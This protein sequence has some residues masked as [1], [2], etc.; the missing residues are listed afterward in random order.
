MNNNEVTI[1]F[2]Y[3]MKVQHALS[4][5]GVY[6]PSAV[7]K[8]TVT[9]S[10]TNNDFRDIIEFLCK[11]LIELDLSD[12]SFEK[13]AYL[14]SHKD[15]P[16]LTSVAFPASINRLD[17]ELFARWSSL[18]HITVDHYNTVYASKDGVLF[19]RDLTKLV[20][21]PTG[22]KGHF[23]IPDTVEV[24][25]HR[26]FAR[27]KGMTSVTIPGSVV[28]VGQESFAECSGLT[29]VVIPESVVTLGYRAF[30]NCTELSSVDMPK[31]L[32][33]KKNYVFEKCEKMPHII[34]ERKKEIKKEK[35]ARLQQTSAC[36]WIN[37]LMNNSKYPYRIDKYLKT[38]LQLSVMITNRLKLEIP[39]P[40]RHF[41]TIIPK[42]METI[43]RYEA[44]I[45]ENENEIMVFISDTTS[46]RENWKNKQ[47]RLT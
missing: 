15:C 43:E 13:D 33:H 28:T 27:C 30:Y 2:S 23:V 9:G 22:R 42:L 3:G 14:W 19:S 4:Y 6:E 35:I 45:N 24:I 34:E 39:V 41:Q 17:P 46:D 18:T 38:R 29:S 36:D 16:L 10:M 1:R 44:C 21:Y 7:K 11:T 37:S 40:Y 32:K 8:L 26:A 25:G 31:S 12:V 5:A 47:K 20:K